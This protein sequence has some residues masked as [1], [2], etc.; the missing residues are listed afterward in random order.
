MM[1]FLLLAMEE[2]V[3]KGLMRE[4]LQGRPLMDREK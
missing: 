1:G 3:E 4:S 2:E